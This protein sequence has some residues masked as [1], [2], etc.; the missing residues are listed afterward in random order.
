MKQ[1][2]GQSTR[3]ALI[4]LGVL[5][6]IL[7]AL[8]IL[9][10]STEI[11]I[12][13][14]IVAV[15]FGITTILVVRSSIPNSSMIA[16]T[17]FCVSGVILAD[18]ATSGAPL[19]PLS[20]LGFV[21]VLVIADKVSARAT[22]L[23]C[24]VLATV[25]YPVIAFLSPVQSKN[26]PEDPVTII[27]ITSILLGLGLVFTIINSPQL[28][29]AFAEI[30]TKALEL[31]STLQRLTGSLSLQHTTKAGLITHIENLKAISSKQVG[32]FQE[33]ITSLTQISSTVTELSQTAEQ[34]YTSA[35]AVDT[36]A[37]RS[38]N[39]VTLSQAAG[40]D[41]LCAMLLIKAQMQEIVA[42]ILA[43][44]AR[45]QSVSEVT[46]VVSKIAAN[47]H[48]LALN[49]AIEAAG[50]G[51]AGKR[52]AAVASEV[53]KLSQQTQSEAVRIREQLADVKR[54]NDA[55]VMATE[56]GLKEADKG[57]ASARNAMDALAS[58]LEAMGQT[59]ELASM[60][61]T[62]TGQQKTASTQVV[63]A[64]QGSL[65]QVAALNE[66]S[67]QI[68]DIATDLSTLSARLALDPS[69]VEQS[70]PPDL[71]TPPPSSRIERQMDRGLFSK[72][73]HSQSGIITT[74]VAKR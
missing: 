11:D 31:K 69:N 62:S 74:S 1:L 18:M 45:I 52:F 12:Y 26:Q 39:A 27:A 13:T 46:D 24:T 34:I 60:I 43:L 7:G 42:S 4:V 53:K 6:I 23:F 32:A 63:S 28:R 67:T 54:A 2:P 14:G 70:T 47:T 68:F 72:L 58:V 20:P 38:M 40:Q 33:E 56:Q 35:V 15:G 48:L 36:S 61:K 41:S 16:G 30:Q 44:N 29:A 65:G 50:A 19:D 51:E 55:S 57:A 5:E 66:T 59:T 73:W 17:I 22:V 25:T 3:A 10:P 49:A 9:A 8:A 71:P 37:L 64:I 21:L